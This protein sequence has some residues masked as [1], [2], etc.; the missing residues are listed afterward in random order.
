MI[1]LDIQVK[2]KTRGQELSDQWVR[3]A[4]GGI[5]PQFT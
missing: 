5:L 3:T 4:R 2:M 1:S